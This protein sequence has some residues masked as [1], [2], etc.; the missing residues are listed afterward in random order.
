MSAKQY[1]LVRVQKLSPPKISRIFIHKFLSNLV[2]DRQTDRQ[3]NK[4]SENIDSLAQLKI[5][6]ISVICRVVYKPRLSGP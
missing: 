6:M 4:Q 2:K 5:N 1:V 3:T